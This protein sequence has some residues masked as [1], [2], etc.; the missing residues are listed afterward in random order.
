VSIKTFKCKNCNLPYPLISEGGQLGSSE[1]LA[2]YTK[3]VTK[4]LFI[5]KD[6]DEDYQKTLDSLKYWEL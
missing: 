5:S 4:G 1:C 3:R 2:C 6:E